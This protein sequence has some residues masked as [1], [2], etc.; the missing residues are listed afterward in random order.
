LIPNETDHYV[1]GRWMKPL[2][3][4]VLSQALALAVLNIRILLPN[5][6]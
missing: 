5:V 2:Q 4:H 1:N 3:D 6:S